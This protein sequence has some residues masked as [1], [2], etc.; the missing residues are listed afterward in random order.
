MGKARLTRTLL[1]VG[2][3]PPDGDTLT[4]WSAPDRP[5]HAQPTGTRRTARPAPTHRDALTDG[6]VSADRDDT[7]DRTDRTVSTDRDAPDR[8]PHHRSPP[9][10]N[11]LH[12][13]LPDG[14]AWRTG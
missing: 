3:C 5:G 10:P 12:R 13:D 11:A 2:A 4:D 14:P 9:D 8:H 6:T 1:V 7:T